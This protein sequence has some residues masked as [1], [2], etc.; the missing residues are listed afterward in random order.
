MVFGHQARFGDEIHRD[1]I[2]QVGGAVVPDAIGLFGVLL[3]LG[4]VGKS[5]T[6]DVLERR[7]APVV[8]NVVAFASVHEVKACAPVERIGLIH[9]EH[10]VESG[11][12]QAVSI[13][14]LPVATAFA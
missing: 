7:T 2:V 11:V 3:P 13:N 8:E 10:A 12:L 4:V 14:R 5:G 9:A 6:A 1:D